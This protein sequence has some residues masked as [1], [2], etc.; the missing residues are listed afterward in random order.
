[1]KKIH[2]YCHCKDCTI[3]IKDVIT[4]HNDEDLG[5]YIDN[6]HDQ[7][8]TLYR[9]YNSYWSFYTTDELTSDEE[10]IIGV[11]FG[12]RIETLEEFNKLSK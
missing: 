5:I 4:W 3:T 8:N 6:F 9:P 7:K 11:D 1:M 2:L 12:D 10:L